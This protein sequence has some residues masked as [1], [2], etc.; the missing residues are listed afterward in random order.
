MKKFVTFGV[1]LLLTITTACAQYI[2]PI[3]SIQKLW[4]TTPG[5]KTPES[6][7]YDT[8]NKT[9]YVSNIDGKS[10]E[11]DGN[12]FISTLAANG[13]YLEPQ[14][15]KGL[16]APKGMGILNGHLFVTNI[17]EVV[18]I[19]IQTATIIKRY[20]I[21][22]AK[23]LNDIAIDPKTGMIFM[24]D[25]S[26][27]QVFVLSNGTAT[28]WLDGPMFKGANGLFLRGKHLF[29]GAGNNILRAD[30]ITGEVTVS[31]SN[32]GSV[33][34]LYVSS[35]DTF[36]YSDWIGSVFVAKSLSENYRKPELILNT[37]TENANAADFG[38]IVYKHMMLIPTFGG[39]KVVCYTLDEIK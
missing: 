11:K 14:W 18:E 27:G 35:D 36:I 28:L 21:P 5:L 37:M 24:T 22:G 7:F 1:I 19:N 20:P 32:T 29:I 30:I 6:V 39:N 25:T 8:I 13:R 33:D 38:V 15:V 26:T 9:I 2:R 31:V 23:F 16:D 3:N 4:E 10:D 12:G 17:D 34:G